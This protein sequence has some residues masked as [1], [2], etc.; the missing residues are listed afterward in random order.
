M[1]H[2]RFVAGAWLGLHRTQ[3]SIFGQLCFDNIVPPPVR[4][5]GRNDVTWGGHHNVGI[6]DGPRV[7]VAKLYRAR[8]VRWIPHRS[9]GVDPL[10]NRRDFALT[11]GRIVF[12][13]FD[14]D[15]TSDVP[16]RHVAG[17]HLPF[18]RPR[19]GSCV[20][21]SQQGHWRHRSR[22]M[23]LLTGTLQ[24]WRDVLREG[25]LWHSNEV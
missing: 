9:A 18:D 11:Q 23:A 14:T 8:H 16:R 13:L 21:V 19:P 22:P 15:I 10:H 24:D 1:M 17:L 3:P 6:A 25:H 7:V 2:D 12:E 5:F 4:T 20:L